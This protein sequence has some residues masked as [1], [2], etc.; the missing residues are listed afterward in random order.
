MTEL[1]PI[2]TKDGAPRRRPWLVPALATLGILVVAIPVLVKVLP[3]ANQT[4][5]EQVANAFLTAVNEHDGVA[6][7]G[8]WATENNQDEVNP[9][10]WPAIAEIDR[11]LG[12]QYTDVDCV[13]L[14]PISFPDGTPAIAVKCTAFVQQDLVRA[15]GLEATHATITVYVSDGEIVRA[16]GDE[17]EPNTRSESMA[18]FE[19]WVQRT[20]PDDYETMYTR[21]AESYPILDAEILA[22]WEERVDEFVAEMG[23]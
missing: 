22:L 3:L 10:E 8:M 23:G 7:R 15:L 5:A 19:S 4:P 16:S 9:D 20:H 1:K 11:V 12:L 6:I 21:A 13:E 17:A 2:E 14:A 18:E